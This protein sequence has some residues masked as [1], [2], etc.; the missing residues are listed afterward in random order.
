M[1]KITDMLKLFARWFVV[2]VH[3][4]G[5][6][7]IIGGILS[8]ILFYWMSDTLGFIAMVITIWMVY[9]F[10]NP[11]RVIPSR[12]GLIVAPADGVVES[13][14]KCVAPSELELGEEELTRISIVLSIFDV[15]VNRIPIHGKV[16]KL[17][18][19]AGKTFSLSMNKNSD[20]NERQ[21]IK[22]TLPKGEKEKIEKAIGMVMIAGLLNNR[23][24]CDLV[25]HQDVKTGERF[26][27]IRFGS[28]VDIFLPKGVNPLVI[29]GQR[30][31]GGETVLGDLKSRE[32]ARTGESV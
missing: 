27:I 7:F 3:N 15:H 22:L 21:L 30:A 29:E 23:I 20:D 9:F 8:T 19:I 31:V 13:V 14:R 11:E 1:E 28:R 16:A 25:D 26:G 5:W 10:R 24:I 4:E 32:A 2:P 12:E 17:H 6:V 18:Y